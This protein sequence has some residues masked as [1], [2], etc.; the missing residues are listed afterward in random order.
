MTLSPERR[1]AIARIG[2]LALSAQRDPRDYTAAARAKFRDSF[3]TGHGCR[4]CPTI[5]IPDDLPSPEQAR[6]AAALRSLHFSRL[7]R[8]RRPDA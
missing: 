8:R 3:A 2:G 1:S 6:R 4:V 5:T 7:G